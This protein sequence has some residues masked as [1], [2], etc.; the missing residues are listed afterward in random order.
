LLVYR[1]E[2]VRNKVSAVLAKSLIKSGKAVILYSVDKYHYDIPLE[3]LDHPKHKHAVYFV[4]GLCWG[5]GR[6]YSNAYR[7]LNMHREYL[8]EGN[9]KAI[10]WLTIN[11]AKQLT[12][13]SPDFWAFRHKVVEFPDLPSIEKLTPPKS[14][15]GSF[16]E[17]YNKHANDFLKWIK[18]AERLYSLGCFDEAIHQF[19]RILR[20]YPDEKAVY[21]QIAEA[22]LSRGRLPAANRVLKKANK[23]ITDKP[24]LLKELDR[25]N[26]AVKS[27]QYSGGGFLELTA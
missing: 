16:N 15:P 6:G 18:T 17:L 22:Y 5:G 25:L 10:F 3:L 27:I 13:F 23:E 21:L 24:Y 4:S 14:F 26:R 12:R 2:H 1:S 9:I 8:V 11:E 19:R 7:A 20:K